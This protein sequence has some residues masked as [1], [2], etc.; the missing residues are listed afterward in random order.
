[1]SLKV[2]LYAYL[3]FVHAIV[4]AVLIWQRD[5]LGWWLFALELVLVSSLTLGLRGIRV[6]MK[7]HEIGRTLADVIESGEY[8]MRYPPVRHREI[9]RVIAAYN[10]MLENLQHEWLRLGEQRGF[11]ERFL[12]VTPVGILIFDFDEKIS[13]VNPR[14]CELL[15]EAAEDLSGRGLASSSSSSPVAKALATLGIEE[16]RMITDAAGR[17]LRCQRARFTD[18]GFHRSYI[19]IEELTTEL[20][21]SERETYEKL[22]RMIAHEVTNTV[23]ATNSLLES[24]RN[25]A[26]ELGSDEHRT[27]Y[28]NALDVLI[29]RNRSLNEFTKGFSDLV[30][31]PEPQRHDVEVRELLNAMRTMFS[32]S[33]AER[34][35]ELAVH[36]EEGLP[37]VSMDRNQMDQVVINVIRN[38]AEAIDRDGRIEILAR[39]GP[40]RVEI[41][42]TDTGAGLGEQT[43]EHLF[44]P[45]FTTKRHGQGLGLTLV[46]EILTQHA[47][48][49]A[50]EPAG[51]GTRFRIEMPIRPDAAKSPLPAS[52]PDS[53]G[54]GGWNQQI[55]QNASVI[56]GKS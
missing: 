23:A 34:G 31:L 16:T 1:M 49:Y 5:V 12:T 30:K 37:P 3:V 45:F 46:K 55:I 11:L 35:I 20:N 53:G 29:A 24:C 14:A 39:G 9:D 42:I 32:A 38:A 15:G 4:G 21:R 43:R 10:R 27:D 36:S 22:I 50:L 56:R 6:A 51:S 17:R 26:V 18:R 19:L 40:K 47:F 44:T 48:G 13:L 7:P 41:W 33:L 25:Y 52:Q 54:T 28:E 8:G 2:R